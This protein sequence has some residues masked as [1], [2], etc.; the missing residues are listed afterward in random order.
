MQNIKNI[1]NLQTYISTLPMFFQRSYETKISFF[2]ITLQTFFELIKKW[3]KK[4]LNIVVKCAKLISSQSQ[5]GWLEELS[6]KFYIKVIEIEMGTEDR[7]I[8]A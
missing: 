5:M 4:D 1:V 8:V 7:E 6:T 3:E 2:I